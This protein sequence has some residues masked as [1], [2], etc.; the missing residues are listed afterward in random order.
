MIMVIVPAVELRVNFWLS[1]RA[2]MWRRRW[3]VFRP[4]GGLN[5][6]ASGR[7]GPKLQRN[8]KR[9]LDA[10][11]MALIGDVAFFNLSD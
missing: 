6:V 4:G 9:V 8:R 1:G 11:V 3:P 7:A 2:A 5:D 10:R